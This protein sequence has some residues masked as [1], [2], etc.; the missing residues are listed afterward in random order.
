MFSLE[1]TLEHLIS[2]SLD[3]S[4]V[5]GDDTTLENNFTNLKKTDYIHQKAPNQIQV[6]ES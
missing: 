6:L 1:L 4:P 3:I 5:V 2:K